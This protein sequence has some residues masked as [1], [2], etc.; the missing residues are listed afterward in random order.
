LKKAGNGS[1]WR[2]FNFLLHQIQQAIEPVIRLQQVLENW[3]QIET[4]LNERSRTRQPQ[5]KVLSS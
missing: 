2:V 5:V 1:A 4:D 3:N